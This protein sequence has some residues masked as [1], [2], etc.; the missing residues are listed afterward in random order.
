MSMYIILIKKPSMR[1]IK[2]S[3]VRD[4]LI[5]LLQLYGSKDKLFE[6]NLFWVGQYDPPP[7]PL[8]LKLHIG[9]RTN[10]K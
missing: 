8:T 4:V 7:P 3:S 9:R 1:K 10:P 6:D 5:I 2:V